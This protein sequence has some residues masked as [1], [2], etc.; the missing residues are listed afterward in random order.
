[1]LCN[2][3]ENEITEKI[4]GDMTYFITHVILV[5]FYVLFLFFSSYTYKK[6]EK[7]LRRITI[8]IYWPLLFGT[9]FRIISF[10]LFIVYT[11][12]FIPQ[13]KYLGNLL[14]VLYTLPAMLFL[15][16]FS[17]IS[18]LLV[19]YGNRE[20]TQYKTT[21]KMLNVIIYIV[22][23]IMIILEF[24]LSP[25][26]KASLGIP[27]SPAQMIIQL[28]IAF[29]YL[30]ASS[31][32]IINVKLLYG[33]YETNYDGKFDASANFDFKRKYYVIA[34]IGCCCFLI[35][36]IIT[37]ITVFNPI[38]PFGVKDIFYYT[39]LEIIPISLL[40]NITNGLHKYAGTTGPI[41]E[42]RKPLL[43]E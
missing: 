6:E 24:T 34:F 20:V 28:F 16:F 23:I 9:L 2:I 18:L 32:S 7:C 36:S 22:I 38:D 12:S 10:S 5:G 17:S 39:L 40:L 33:D 19:A 31:I 26:E 13:S 27:N 8:A 15:T 37:T 4:F 29:I 21:V 3:E 1:M 25:N 14:F 11:E 42:D 43:S 30:F 35:R 41:N